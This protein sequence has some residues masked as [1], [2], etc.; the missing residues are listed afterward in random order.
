MRR[1]EVEAF[2]GGRQIVDDAVKA[3]LLKPCCNPPE[4]RQ[5][6]FE[7]AAVVAVESDLLANRYPGG[8]K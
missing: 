7:T 8:G 2:L 6:F 4:R 1:N 3:G 5:S